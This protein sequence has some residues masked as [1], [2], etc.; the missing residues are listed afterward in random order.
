[1]A[2]KKEVFRAFFTKAV[3]DAIIILMWTEEQKQIL[4]ILTGGLAK[5]DLLD[6]AYKM[7]DALWECFIKL[8]RKQDQLICRPGTLD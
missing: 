8:K 4:L 1:M 7:S 3:R 2:C 6:V 5:T